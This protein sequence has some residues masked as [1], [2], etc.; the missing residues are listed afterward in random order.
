MVIANPTQPP[1]TQ[2]TARGRGVWCSSEFCR[3][4]VN[5]GSAFGDSILRN[6]SYRDIPSYRDPPYRDT[7]Y[8]I[9]HT[10]IG[11]SIIRIKPSY[12]DP[13]YR[14]IPSYRDMPSYGATFTTKDVG[15]ISRRRN[16]STAQP[17][18]TMPAP[19]H[20]HKKQHPA[21]GRGVECAS[22]VRGKRRKR[23]RRFHLTESVIPR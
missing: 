10:A 13:P 11:D 16:P 4:A 15:W 22:R 7:N 17:S 6:P 3:F 8:G 2:K 14:D 23:L 9:R 5:D 18:V 19:R 21:R 1:K 20:R 12:R